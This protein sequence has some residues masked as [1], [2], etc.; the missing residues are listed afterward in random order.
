[1]GAAWIAVVGAA[2][3]LALAGLVAVLS[4]RVPA[5][6]EALVV[7]GRR[8]RVV[9]RR[10]ALVAPG[11]ARVA[12]V[13]LAAHPLELGLDARVAEGVACTVT[14]RGAWQVGAGDR[15]VEAVARHLPGGTAAAGRQVEEIVAGRVR[16]AIGAEPGPGLVEGDTAARLA[17][18]ASEAA[19]ADLTGLG[20]ELT[21][22]EV[23]A[24]S[25]PAG[26]LDDL[27]HPVVARAAAA[28]GHPPT[29]RRV[30]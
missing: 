11:V 15:C 22:L 12:R 7:T 30:R 24:L 4:W 3:A 26:Y 27:V 6:H 23:V 2:G 10:G 8:P 17:G 16:A 25:D 1:V 5:A 14:V 18:A 9:R 13:D 28:A 21:H 20:L 19:A 29:L